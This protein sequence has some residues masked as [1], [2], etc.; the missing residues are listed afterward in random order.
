MVTVISVPRVM[1]CAVQQG[2]FWYETSEG[3]VGESSFE[4]AVGCGVVVGSAEL[5]CYFFAGPTRVCVARRMSVNASTRA[6]VPERGHLITYERALHIGEQVGEA[7]KS[8]NAVATAYK[9]SELD[10]FGASG[11]GA[12]AA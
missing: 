8:L 6:L 11:M 3:F 2:F 4:F 10:G 5:V 1:P 9:A 7:I 12:H